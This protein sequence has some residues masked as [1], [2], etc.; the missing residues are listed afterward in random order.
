MLILTDRGEIAV[1]DLRIGDHLITLSGAARRLRWV[2]RRSY[3]GR[4][5]AG[6]RD[7]LPVL[8]RRD[9][10]ADG[11]PRRDL[12][13]SP[14]H[15]MYLDGVLI[16]ASALVNGSSIVQ[17]GEVDQ[18]EYIHLELETHDVILA[19]GAASET[20]VDDD[21]RGMFHNAMEYHLLYPDA[22]RVPARYC[23]P[24]VEDG[25]ALE[26]VRRRLAVRAH[27][28]QSDAYLVQSGGCWAVWSVSAAIEY[29]AG[30]AMRCRR[31]G[32]WGCAS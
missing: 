14:L 19:E 3:A 25:E 16:P 8:I 17:L 9:A 20:F 26:A 2:G 13:V 29:P 21:S 4:F 10:L 23:A 27:L 31:I 30:R 28:P 5:A 15:A 32:R 7:I 18:V 24:R 12:F 11:V 1:E 6:N 22:P